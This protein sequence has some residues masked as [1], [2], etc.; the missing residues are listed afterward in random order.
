MGDTFGGDWHRPTNPQR[1]HSRRELQDR[2]SYD[3][4]PVTGPGCLLIAMTILA[5]LAAALGV[6]L[7]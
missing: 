4:Q 7:G 6:V 1:G 5:A 3:N 2:A